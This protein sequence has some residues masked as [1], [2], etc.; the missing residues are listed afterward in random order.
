MRGKF[1]HGTAVWAWRLEGGLVRYI[2]KCL[3]NLETAI[4]ALQTKI[5]KKLHEMPAW[6]D[7]TRHKYPGVFAL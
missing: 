4:A 7:G 1:C 2:E 3:N 6:A 5:A